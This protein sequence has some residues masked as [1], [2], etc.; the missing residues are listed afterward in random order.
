MKLH[1]KVDEMFVC[2]C[3][4]VREKSRPLMGMRIFCRQVLKGRSRHSVFG[5]CYSQARFQ[6]RIK[7]R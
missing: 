1:R 3:V 4:C 2:A 7:G 5:V 6:H